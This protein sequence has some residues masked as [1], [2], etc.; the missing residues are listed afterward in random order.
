MRVTAAI[1][2]MAEAQRHTGL[3]WAPVGLAVGIAIYF[4]LRAEPG[5]VIGWLALAAGIIGMGAAIM[6]P[7]LRILIMLALCFMGFGVA[8]MHTDRVAAPILQQERYGVVVGRIV[9]FDRSQSNRLR[10][11]LDQLHIP[12]LERD[13]TP[14][15]VRIVIG[16][17]QPQSAF[18][19]GMRVMTMARLGP[20]PPPVEPTG[21]DFRRH[22]WFLK[23]G[24]IGYAATPVVLAEPE[25]SEQGAHLLRLR[26]WLADQIRARMP[27]QTGGFAAA[28]L[29][30]DR[31]GI[32]PRDLVDLRASNLAHLLA[33][34]GLH[35]G[36]LTGVVF[37]SVR[38]ALVAVPGLALRIPAKRYAAVAALLTGAAYL[39]I[40]GASI[41]TQRAFIM[42]AV[43]FCAVLID[44]PAITL[45]GIAV[46]AIIILLWRPDG[47]MSAGFQMSFAAT[48]ALVAVYGWLSALKQ[49]GRLPR[50]HPAVR[51]VAALALTSLVAGLATAPY[52][53]FHFNQLTKFGLLAN[54]LAVPA[55]GLLVM[56]SALLALV[57]TPLGLDWIGYWLMDLGIAHILRVAHGVA[58]LDGSVMPVASGPSW[59]LGVLSLGALAVAIMRG[60]ARLGG[61]AGVVVALVAWGMADRP[62][63]LVDA[64]GKLIGIDSAQG[65]VLNKVRGSGFAARVWLENDGDAVEQRV[66][67]ERPALLRTRDAFHVERG[68]SGGDVL[69][70]ASEDR[71]AVPCAEGTLVVA[72]NL[73][74]P[75]VG[76]C[77]FLGA[78][79]LSDHGAHA[80][81]NTR[82]G[83]LG[84]PKTTLSVT[85]RRPWSP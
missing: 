5:A 11:T 83:T 57:L 43:I 10:L 75:P 31:S 6:A 58:G 84:P 38:L 19:P 49:A 67:G 2:G 39:A 17:A 70:S 60:P 25:G 71:R 65:R 27:P 1:M 45:R 32:D 54:I 42:A 63:V 9:G 29:T 20:P 56:P 21:F 34:S 69:W 24:A 7:R 55:M 14:E 68:A 79:D 33:I 4:N 37:V 62:A 16:G 82:G 23:L 77:R 66:A 81:Y 52:S 72:P 74:E 35:M 22:A 48:I 36:L 8:K 73:R 40:S 59:V 44:R 85:G 53:A 61:V 76:S 13:E 46:S 78:A 41:A 12:G 30:G 28:I 80:F 47:L 26:M 51:W 18:P 3:L 50:A 15:R 64:D